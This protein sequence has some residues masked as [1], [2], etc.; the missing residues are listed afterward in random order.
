MKQISGSKN[1]HANLVFLV[2]LFS[3]GREIDTEN[4]DYLNEETKYQ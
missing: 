3:S 4:N 2:Y 1:T